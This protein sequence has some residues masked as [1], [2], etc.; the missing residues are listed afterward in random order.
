MQAKAVSPEIVD[1]HELHIDEHIKLLISKTTERD[2][3]LKE[4]LKEHI[5]AH[6]SLIS[7]QSDTAQLISKFE[8]KEN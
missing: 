2:R 1:N 8:E 3:E 4:R 7:L 5:N 6:R